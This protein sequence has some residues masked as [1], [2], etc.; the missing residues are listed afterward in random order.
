MKY[1]LL[2]D[3]HLGVRADAEH[4][5]KMQMRFYR[6]QLVPFMLERKICTILHAGDFFDK[7]QFITLKTMYACREFIELLASNDI[8]MNLICGN[9]DVLYRDTNDVNSPEIMLDHTNLSVFTQPKEFDNILMVPWINSKNAVEFLDIMRESKAK[10]CIGHFEIAGFEMHKGS[11]CEHGMDAALFNRFDVVLSGHFH[12]RSTK[13]NITYLGSPFEMTWSDF[14]DQKY[15]YVLDSETGELEAIPV[16]ERMFYRINWN[17]DEMT[18]VPE[19]PESFQGK[20]VRVVADRRE[21]AYSFDAWLST[22]A[23]QNPADLQVVDVQVEISQDV[24]TLIAESTKSN[25]D[26]IME[27]IEASGHDEQTRQ[28]LTQHMTELY[29]ECNSL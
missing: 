27:F 14:D 7:R 19:W 6:E 11:V 4:L 1:V 16:K 12:T 21:A 28:M 22:I 3:T 13:G 23:Q 24:Q 2:T 15:F 8:S 17:K 18:C 9:H 20:H 26:L 10:I 25:L 29:Y 5:A